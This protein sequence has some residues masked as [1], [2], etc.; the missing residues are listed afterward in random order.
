MSIPGSNCAPSLLIGLINMVMFKPR[1]AE[2]TI[3]NETLNATIK[4]PHCHLAE[5]Y[6]HQTI[7]ES[8]L[9]IVAV[10]CIPVMLFGKP[11][12]LSLCGSRKPRL[13]EPRKAHRVRYLYC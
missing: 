4:A 13:R 5:W 3:Y 12:W 1:P 7:V 11:I 6:P 8:T 2:F 9:V 10:A